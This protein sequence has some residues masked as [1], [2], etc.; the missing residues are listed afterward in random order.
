MLVYHGAVNP[1][2]DKIQLKLHKLKCCLLI[3][4]GSKPTTGIQI[5]SPFF[6]KRTEVLLWI[7]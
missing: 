1:K 7:P 4:L 5:F 6:D 3:F 2:E